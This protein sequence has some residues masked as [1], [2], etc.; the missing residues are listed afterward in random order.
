MLVVIRRGLRISAKARRQP[1]ELPWWPQ[2]AVDAVRKGDWIEPEYL[3]AVGETSVP[4]QGEWVRNWLLIR[5][6]ATMDVQL[7]R[8]RSD[9]PCAKPCITA[10]IALHLHLHFHPQHYHLTHRLPS[11]IPKT[12]S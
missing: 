9:S 12:L 7:A 5:R 3:Q 11:R 8:V 1:R 2:R 6:L 10:S 4:L